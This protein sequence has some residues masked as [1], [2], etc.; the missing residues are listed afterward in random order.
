MYRT[1]RI[2]IKTGHG[3]AGVS[4]KENDSRWIYVKP[5]RELSA[6]GIKGR[7]KKTSR[8][9]P[10]SEYEAITAAEKPSAVERAKEMQFEAE[11]YMSNLRGWVSYLSWMRSGL[12]GHLGGRG[13]G[14]A[15]L[16]HSS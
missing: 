10:G 2:T 7:R 8:R 11:L 6:G 15:R 12:V 16:A 5:D 14:E 4:E 3:D 1:P 13:R 9:L